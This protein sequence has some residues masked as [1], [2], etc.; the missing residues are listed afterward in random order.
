[1]RLICG[2]ILTTL[3]LAG[4]ALA[5][6]PVITNAKVSPLSGTWACIDWNTDIPASSFVDYG[7]TASYGKTESIASFITSHQVQLNGLAIGTTY[8]YRIRGAN[9]AGQS[10]SS[11]DLTFT[12]Q[13]D[14]WGS[15]SNPTG[16]PLGGGAGYSR[17]IQRSQATRVVSDAAGLKN[18][19]KAAVSGN[20]IYIDDNAMIDMSPQ[21][22]TVYIPAGVT[23]ASGRGNN[24][25]AG[26]MLFNATFNDTNLQSGSVPMLR[27]NGN[28][29]RITGLRL[30]GPHQTRARAMPMYHGIY[31]GHSNVE[32]DNCEFYGNNYAAIEAVVGKPGPYV[33]HCYF[34]RNSRTGVGYGV[35]P[36]WTLGAKEGVIEGN[37][38]DQHRHSIAGTGTTGQSYEARYNLVLENS[39]SHIFDMHGGAD[40]GDGT[41]IA[42]STIKIHHNTVRNSDQGAVCIRGV[43]T[44][45]CWINNN[46][47]YRPHD[48]WCIRQLNATGNFYETNNIF[49]PPT[50][51]ASGPPDPANGTL[52]ANWKMDE[53]SGSTVADSSG[54]G[55]TGTLNN[56]NVS[57]AWVTGHSGN[58]VQFPGGTA[59]LNCGAINQLDNFAIDMWLKFTD[60]S[61]TEYVLSNN[62]FDLYFRGG[63]YGNYLFFRFKIKEAGPGGDIT[64]WANKTGIKSATQVATGVWYHVTLARKGNKLQ[65]Y[66]NGTLEGEL[67]ALAGFTVDTS[68]LGAFRLGCS[69]I[70]ALD[71]VYYFIP[72]SGAT[73]AGNGHAP[74]LTWSG[75]PNYTH[76]GLNPENGAMGASYTFRV[77]YTDADNNPPMQGYPKLHVLRNG[78]DFTSFSPIV[79]FPVD[80][81]TPYTSGRVYTCNYRL[82]RGSD[83]SYYFEAFDWAGNEAVGAA[84]SPLGGPT[85]TGGNSI[86]I[87]FWPWNGTNFVQNVIYPSSGN[88]GT[89]F[90]FRVGYIDLD[91]EIAQGGGPKLKI[92]N[93]SGVDIPGS[94]FLMSAMDSGQ[95]C[96]GVT[97]QMIRR[98]PAGSYKYQI[99]ASDPQGA[100]AMSIPLSAGNLSVA[101]ASSAWCD[102][103]TGAPA[104]LRSNSFQVAVSFNAT[105]TGF[106]AS[107]VTLTNGTISGFTGSGAFYSFTVTANN[108]GTVTVKI[109]AGVAS[110]SNPASATIT[111]NYPNPIRTAAETGWELM[112]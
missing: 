81:T 85:V 70:G 45:G 31:S 32:I 80:A 63:S 64:S 72:G 26:G 35:C 68:S 21:T 60:L 100:A 61:T 66:M 106:T 90:D 76:D 14:T 79:M 43:P 89:S 93:A 38:F 50:A 27:T 1:M 58:A 83:Y 94:P 17:I 18:A 102:G 34:H 111:R 9:A 77:K 49:G 98:F 42:G 69:L 91:N 101:S 59:E 54:N 75:E 112:Q 37:I 15:D 3:I 62:V 39:V 4:S 11:G 67:D 88:V 23:L 74:T 5:A 8:H 57:T 104:T 65:L 51:L 29:V 78:V 56:M 33:H 105:V 28:N 20:I 48:S 52:I 44:V 24:G 108:Y 22:A 53:G 25:S 2:A 95:V 103:Y 86:P 73:P 10:A 12:T 109:P 96:N 84:T 82:P 55:H 46:R 47:F 107:D 110:P 36:G 6:P 97:Y 7:P 87:L 41:N 13:S 99:V 40:R 92:L 16:N 19:L 71:D 30:V